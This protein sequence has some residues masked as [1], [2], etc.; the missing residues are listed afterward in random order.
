MLILAI[1]SSGETAS[2]AVVTEGKVLAEINLANKLTHSQTLMPLI[3]FMMRTVAI[4]LPEIDYIALSAGPGSFTGLRIGAGIAKAIC[5]GA[6]KDLYPYRRST[7]SR[8]T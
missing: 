5:H 6:E 3:D 8:I 7:P 4:E 2:A 1:E